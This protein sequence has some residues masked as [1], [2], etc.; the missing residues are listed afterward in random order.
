MKLVDGT[1]LDAYAKTSATLNERLSVFSRIC[2][3]VAFAHCHGIIHRDLKPENIMVAQFGE[4]LVLD[5]GVAK[6]VGIERESSS[7]QVPAR[8]ATPPVAR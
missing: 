8:V 6:I 5:W 7:A 4:V 2:E 3:T 1:R